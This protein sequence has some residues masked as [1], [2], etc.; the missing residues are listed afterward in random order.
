MFIHLF[1]LILFIPQ[2]QSLKV[3]Q[4][5]YGKLR[6]IT[7]WSNDKNH[8]YMFKSVPF[9]KPPVG[10]L[11]FAKPQNPESWSGILDA[12]KYS[13]AC[14]S[15]SSSTSTPQKHYSEDCLYINIFTSE[16]CLNS[17]CPVIVYFHGGAYNLD[18]AIMFNDTFILDRYA[19]E[20]VVFVIPAVRL[21]VFGQLY[22]GPSDLLSE[23][24][25]LY[26]AVQALSFVHSEINYFGGDSKRVTAMGHSSG[27]TIVDAL[28][29]SKL[30]DPGVKLFQQMIVL[31]A[32]GMFGFYDMVVDNSFA[33]VEKF[34]CYNG[35]KDDRPN[36]NI[37]E[38]LDCM[39]QIDGREM[40]LMQR[41]MEEVDD[42]DFRSVLRG[43]PFLESNGKIA[44][45]KKSPPSRNLLYGTTEHEFRNVDHMNPYISGIF[46]DFDNPVA[47]ARYYDEQLMANLE[48]MINGD[49]AAIF[50][51]A[52]TFSTAMANTGADV[53]LFETRQK[54]Y[55]FHVSDMQ[56][57]VGIH[58]E[59]Y[60]RPDMDILD[61]FYSKLLVNF[62]KMGVPSPEWAPLD[63]ERMNYLELK[64]DS[65][66]K[67]G[68]VM[69]EGFHEKEM[70]LWF[71][72]MMEFDRNVTKIRQSQGLPPEH[73]DIETQLKYW[74][75]TNKPEILTKTT[76]GFTSI[77]QDNNSNTVTTT[78]SAQ[79]S[80][81]KNGSS[82]LKQ[83]WFY[84]IIFLMILLVVL[85][86]ICLRKP[87]REEELPLL[88]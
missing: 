9:A 77:H 23:N 69:L 5:S 22:F 74:E 43:A 53:Y 11:R 19:A 47:V 7:V 78:A 56:Y 35:T 45:L 46:L 54:P 37:A 15:N 42:R 17:K 79:S 26:D 71:G 63:P 88:S 31:S 14:M 80:L 21:G 68:P 25:F 32:T 66:M 61:T 64:V 84:L 51:C 57:F 2:F 65:D 39:R 33:I 38:M 83:W 12:S 73:L 20:D 40:L 76:K 50:I 36:A 8:R 10:N 87:K 58:R 27:G 13:P 6:G 28:G 72:E 62:T 52:S 86:V 60:H 29:F 67:E 59:I 16:K 3:I 44:D 85:I 75:T 81:L 41:H 82:I 48:T 1:L 4:T 30:I 18:S 49:A 55:S 34:G 70:E 24:L